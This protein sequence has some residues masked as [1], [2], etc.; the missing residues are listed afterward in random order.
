MH[1]GETVSCSSSGTKSAAPGSDETPQKPEFTQVTSSMFVDRSAV[2]NSAAMEF[3]A[4]S[5]SSY[6]P[7][8]NDP[9]DPP[10]CGPL[11]WGP[12]PTQAGSV[13]WSTTRSPGTS[14]NF[15]VFHLFL[16]VPAER[17]DFRSL[18][19]K[20]GTFK[21]QG[22]TFTVSP[23]PLQG[24]PSWSTAYRFTVG[25]VDNAGII[26]PYRGL[27]V[28]ALFNQKSGG[29]LSPNDTNALVKLFNDQVAKLEAI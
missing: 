3:T 1:G 24:L 16:L 11:Y 12:R 10:E 27:Y 29:D 8:S 26:G 6:P 23:L 7:G 20:C 15:K 22:V 2:P 4:P 9:V 21:Y 25:G 17:P 5:I 13:T 19:G 18:L 28:S 14:T